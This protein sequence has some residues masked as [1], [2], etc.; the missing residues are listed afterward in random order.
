MKC[1]CADWVEN[2]KILDAA[3]LLHALRN[4]RQGLKKSFIY[5]PYCGNKLQEV[6]NE[7]AI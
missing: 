4:E 7:R 3:L 1:N 6:E 5:C 2:I